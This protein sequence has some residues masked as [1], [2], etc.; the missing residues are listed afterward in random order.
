MT[1]TAI[2]ITELGLYP[3]TTLHLKKGLN[4]I[5]GESGS[6]KSML[7]RLLRFALGLEHLDPSWLRQ[8]AQ[9]GSVTLLFEEEDHRTIDITRSLNLEGRSRATMNGK[10]L[11]LSALKS[12][13]QSKV[14][15]SQQHAHLHLSDTHYWLTILDRSVNLEV[16][17]RYHHAFTQHHQLRRRCAYEES[18]TL[19]AEHL[20]DL[21]QQL[22]AL[23]PLYEDHAG[24]DMNA[25]DARL[26]V[27]EQ[28]RERLEALTTFQDSLAQARIERHAQR[29]MPHLTQD[30]RDRL[31]Q[32]LHSCADWQN[33]PHHQKLEA[34]RYECEEL[35]QRLGR[36]FDWA[37]KLGMAPEALH[38]HY[39]SLK[40]Q[41]DTHHAAAVLAQS[42]AQALAE[43]AKELAVHASALTAERMK[44]AHTLCHELNTIL[45]TLGLVQTKIS[46]GFTETEPQTEGRDRLDIMMQSHHEA[47][48]RALKDIAS[49]GELARLALVLHSLN[50]QNA[51]YLFDEIDVGISGSIAM[52]VGTYLRRL[53]H[54]RTV[55]VISHTPQV[56]AFAEHLWL[57]EK[58]LSTRP[59]RSLLHLLDPQEHAEGLQLILS[60]HGA[61]AS[62]YAHAHQLIEQASRCIQDEAPLP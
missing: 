50:P 11:S 45:P 36:Y 20:A 1:L 37:R 56:A 34:V 38:E 16:R 12:I 54:H 7:Y 17:E 2:R 6:G 21:E 3:D 28:E 57:I 42:R 55:M 58:D 18:Q 47:A 23:A 51:S 5:I 26:R 14:L 48:P 35:S 49:G 52:K 19:S 53:A 62:A 24:E 31:E 15:L 10:A 40:A 22:S 59:P 43:A 60:G 9:E 61:M 41:W 29:L 39:Q 8:G 32:L 46:I 30:E 33:T 27:L 13:T 4:V 25:L 44:A